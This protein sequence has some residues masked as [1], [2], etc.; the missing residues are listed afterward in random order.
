[1]NGFMEILEGAAVPEEMIEAIRCYCEMLI[2]ENLL[3]NALN[4]I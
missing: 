2:D 4:E 1:M 3:D